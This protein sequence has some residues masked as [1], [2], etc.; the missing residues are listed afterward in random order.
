MRNISVKSEKNTK[1]FL[2][3][4]EDYY[5]CDTQNDIYII[6]DG[7]SRDKK[8]GIYPQDSPA[9]TVSKIFVDSA[10][11]FII[12]NRHTYEDTKQ[13]LYDAMCAGNKQIFK[14]NQS[15]DDDFLPGTVGI[16]SVIDKRNILCY[17][18]IG[19][20]FGM[21]VSQKKCEI[22]TEK[23]TKKIH[24]HIKM[25]TAKEVRNEICNNINHP[26]SYG[27]LNG[28][29]TASNFIVTGLLDV[30]NFKLLFLYTDGLEKFMENIPIDDLLNLN[31]DNIM[32]EAHNSSDDDKTI[33]VINI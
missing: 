26:Y 7:V 10:Y 27:V 6:V 13:L 24:E 31:A 14:Y 2:K 8:N 19:D 5:L 20:C 11:N 23:Q 22:F 1:P 25:Y 18:Y 32:N 16:I 15:I 30:N 33:I 3:P 29:N 21:L 12:K 9:A 17:A 28:C 4:N